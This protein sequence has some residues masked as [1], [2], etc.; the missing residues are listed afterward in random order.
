MND[1]N[2]TN[3]CDL[4]HAFLC[5]SF[6]PTRLH[7]PDTLLKSRVGNSFEM[8]TL[9]CSILIG[10][11]FPAMVVSG[12]A[13]REVTTNDQRRVECPYIPREV[14][15]PEVE[16]SL[17]P[18]YRLHERPFL[19]SRFLLKLEQKK[20]E[21]EHAKL[22]EIENQRQLGVAERESW[23]TDPNDGFRV[24]AWVAMINDLPWC[25][26]EA[27]KSKNQVDDDDEDLQPP[28]AFFIEP[29]TGFRHELDDTSYQGIES[30]WNH[31]NYYVNRQYPTVSISE[32]KWDLSDNEKWEHFLPGEP[33]ELRKLPIDEQKDAMT[34]DEGDEN[35]DNRILATEKHLDMPFSWVEM[36][37]IN[38]V[39][40]EQRYLDGEKKE[41]Y[42]YAIH[43]KFAPFKHEDG[44]MRRLTVYETLDY[45]KPVME[46]MWYE[47]R[48]DL[49]RFVRIDLVTGANNEE[50]QKGRADSL[51]S[52]TFFDD[53]NREVV[54]NFYAASRFDCMERVTWH[55]SYIEEAY[56]NRRDL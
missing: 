54:M 46:Y 22:D 43:E 52:C 28:Q 37:H 20:L 36:L 39:D 7:S 26:K 33:F 56:K 4:I 21:G 48:V 9:L 2:C 23:P 35:V 51:K 5:V 38:A 24:H 30:V 53:P 8:A 29:S 44:L 16:K 32:M 31:Q 17:D 15:E 47:N 41:F 6:Q 42:K 45:E 14:L 49:M 40:F 13:T 19:K 3:F 27:F 55:P 18:K 50:F 10:F 25:Y 12:Y 11:G 34:T 1:D